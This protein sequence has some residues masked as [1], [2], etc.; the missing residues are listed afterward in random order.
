MGKICDTT[1]PTY[2]LEQLNDVR[3]SMNVSWLSNI[4]NADSKDIEKLTMYGPLADLLL[5]WPKRRPPLEEHMNLWSETIR[6]DFLRDEWN[7]PKVSRGKIQSRNETDFAD[8]RGH[9]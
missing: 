2:I 6:A 7:L 3:L 4:P 5:A 9:V 8:T 1:A